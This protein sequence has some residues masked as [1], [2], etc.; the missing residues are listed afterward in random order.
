MKRILAVFLAV[1]VAAVVASCESK[2][3]RESQKKDDSPK[4]PS[5]AS[6]MFDKKSLPP[7]KQG[8]KAGPG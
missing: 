7:S 1:V 6:E 3:S 2:E 4:K 8:G 5:P